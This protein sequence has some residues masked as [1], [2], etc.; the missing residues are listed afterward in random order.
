MEEAYTFCNIITAEANLGIQQYLNSLALLLSFQKGNKQIRLS[1]ER[2]FTLSKIDKVDERKQKQT[3]QATM[4]SF[5]QTQLKLLTVLKCVWQDQCDNQEKL[6]RKQREPPQYL[7]TISKFMKRGKQ[8]VEL[9][10]AASILVN[11]CL[12]LDNKSTPPWAIIRDM[13]C[14]E[15]SFT[16]A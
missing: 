4:L 7:K 12:P 14:K 8:L 9:L 1:F 3:V 5:K 2:V 13:F 16:N 10:M 11:Y 15:L 6:K